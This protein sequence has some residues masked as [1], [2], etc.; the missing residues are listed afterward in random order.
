MPS[1]YR[2]LKGEQPSTYF[3]YRQN[4]QELTRLTIQDHAITAVSAKT[5]TLSPHRP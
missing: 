3:V 2:P 4:A 1:P 5:T